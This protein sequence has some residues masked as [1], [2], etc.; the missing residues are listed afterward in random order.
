MYHDY[1]LNQRLHKIIDTAVAWIHNFNQG[2]MTVLTSYLEVETGNQN[3]KTFNL[4]AVQGRSNIEE[5]YEP[6]S[7]A[8]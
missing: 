5:I 6:K 4:K 1:P 7:C 3:D 8:N 2:V